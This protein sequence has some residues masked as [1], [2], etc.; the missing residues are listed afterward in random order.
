MRGR[1]VIAVYLLSVLLLFSLPS[2][3]RGETTPR[4]VYDAFAEK[5]PLPRI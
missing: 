1:R 3:G 4:E 5:Y 2:C